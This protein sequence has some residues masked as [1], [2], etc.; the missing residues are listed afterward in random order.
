MT[1]TCRNSVLA[2]LEPALVMRSSGKIQRTEFR[3][4]S[5]LQE[6]GALVQWVWFPETA[7]ICVASENLGGESLS[8]GM[9]GWNGV[10]GALEACGSRMSFTRATVQIAGEG[11]RIRADHYRELFDHS[12]ALRTAIH[13]YVEATLVETR[14]L[15]ACAAL[16]SVESRLCRALLDAS[17]QSHGGSALSITQESMA[18]MLG[19]QRTTVALTTSTLQKS[20]LIRS[21]R[22]TIELL[23]LKGIEAASC[24]CRQTIAYAVAAIYASEEEACEA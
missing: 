20:G 8:G 18:H 17:E 13:K 3:R 4:G 15:V 1:F 5:K 21:G 24:S 6:I 10:Y 16:H 14:Q 23:D 19:V 7:L 2:K 11:Y 12:S 9:I 22:G